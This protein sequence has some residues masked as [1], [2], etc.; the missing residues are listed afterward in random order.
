MPLTVTCPGCSSPLRV[1]DEYVGKKLKCPRCQGVIEVPAAEAPAPVVLAEAAEEPP[2]VVLAE[3]PA[4]HV[5]VARPTPRGPRPGE[6][7]T[8]IGEGLPEVRP[9]GR[10]PQPEPAEEPEDYERR[11]RRRKI[12]YKP[13]P[14]CGTGGATRVTWTPWG[15]FY[16]PA[17]LTHVRCPGCGYAYN[18]RSGRSNVVGVVFFTMIP[19]LLLVGIN[20]GLWFA[21]ARLGTVARNILIGLFVLEGIIGGILLVLSLIRPGAHGHGRRPREDDRG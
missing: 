13:C 3:A 21:L 20:V 2:P 11:P 15:S 4:E 12:D 9:A 19:L 18:G 7:A 14:R 16:G 1:R 17:L 5:E 10:K 6:P 8:A